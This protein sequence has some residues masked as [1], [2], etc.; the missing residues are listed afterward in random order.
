MKRNIIKKIISTVSAMV[1]AVS[2]VPQAFAAMAAIPA[3]GLGDVEYSKEKGIYVMAGKGAI[4]SSANG[5]DWVKRSCPVTTAIGGNGAKG[6]TYSEKAGA[7]LIA[8]SAKCLLYSDD[9]V[10]F[11]KIANNV[12]EG[13]VSAVEAVGEYI[14][15]TDAGG[16]VYRAKYDA[17]ESF[18]KLEQNIKTNAW[19]GICAYDDKVFFYSTAAWEGS[20]KIALLENGTFSEP[21]V[22]KLASTDIQRYYDMFY[23]ESLETFVLLYA[24]TGNSYKDSYIALYKDGKFKTVGTVID[25]A[26]SL[27][28]AGDS[29]VLGT[30]V[31]GKMFKIDKSRIES[32]TS[33]DVRE[34]EMPGE[35]T[36]KERFFNIA[37]SGENTVAVG[38]AG[39]NVI[40][41]DNNLNPTYIKQYHEAAE[42]AGGTIAGI[43]NMIYRNAAKPTEAVLS[44]MYVDQAGV[45]MPGSETEAEWAVKDVTPVEAADGITIDSY[46]GLTVN[47]LGEFADVAFTVT[48]T[49]DGECKEKTVT[50]KKPQTAEC[51][52]ISGDMNVTIPILSDEA[53]YRFN[54]EVFDNNGVKIEGATISWII[55]E[56]EGLTIENGLL[57]VK[58]GTPE[59]ECTL[60]AV[61]EY[62]GLTVAAECKITLKEENVPTEAVWREETVLFIPVE[63]E[64]EY[65]FTV[66]IKNQKG[67]AFGVA[68]S[69]LPKDGEYPT[70]VSFKDGKLIISNDA[71]VGS[72]DITAA[73]KES[74]TDDISISLDKMTITVS[75]ESETDI[76]GKNEKLLY[77]AVLTDSQGG[78]VSGD[79]IWTVSDG[80]CNID[81]SGELYIPSSIRS[82]TEV[83]VFASV[84]K[85]AKDSAVL[86]VYNTKKSTSG[87]GGGGGGGGSSSSVIVAPST[88][89]VPVE[90]VEVPAD[91][92]IEEKK[93][94]PFTDM[95]NTLWAK[96]SVKALYE[97]GIVTG[98]TD[99]T[100]EPGRNITRAEFV[101]L[102]CDMLDINDTENSPEFTDCSPDDWY[103]NYVV[104]AYNSGIVKGMGSDYFGARLPLSRQDMAKML[105]G[106]LVKKNVKFSETSDFVDMENADSYALDAIKK[107][108]GLGV[109]SGD[110]DGIFRPKDNTT[111]AEAAVVIN[112]LG[113]YIK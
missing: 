95:E 13:N 109:L 16:R 96:E 68:D 55:D 52:V 83:T 85:L 21:V 28:E 78:T 15:V 71:A 58:K 67:D 35:I 65:P 113:G 57:T 99:D 106:V 12:F 107:L 87:G 26:I 30:I 73:Y 80:A 103:Y 1:M 48:A 82:G 11:V 2:I 23:S 108:I 72:F 104:S 29:I 56:I 31:T 6:I 10:N 17:L 62:S 86:M 19:R 38:G 101:K 79:I 42:P 33:D 102:L 100:F 49:K 40:L 8:P 45:I 44:Y 88:L 112:K 74:F 14:Y 59:T 41:L 93:N 105:E 60:T 25:S 43:D 66:E 22:E 7:F 18:T 98:V 97:K 34:I 77:T 111:R 94:F 89:N 70:G 91:E 27:E 9:G 54:A 69:V 75:G 53:K 32:F 92:D 24:V 61:C 51:I 81:G 5:S 110:S 63:G 20:C 46:G 37:T 39:G 64:V 3:N 36:D 50:T 47:P 84:G 90:S 76:K 4:Y